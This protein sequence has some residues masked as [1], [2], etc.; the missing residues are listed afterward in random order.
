MM[1]WAHLAGMHVRYYP[2][3][4]IRLSRDLHSTQV[5][6]NGSYIK[7]QRQDWS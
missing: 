4:A 1:Q 5:F 3:L 2:E 7:A 6:A